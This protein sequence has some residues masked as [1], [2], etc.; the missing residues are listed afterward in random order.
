MAKT[1]KMTIKYWN[2]LSEGS[3]KRALQYCFPIHGAIVEM[4]LDE[5]PTTKE[6]KN[7]W[8]TTVFKKVRIPDDN[9]AYKTVIDNRTYLP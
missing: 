8:W 7:G 4:L 1:K 9:H 5:K 6:I 3:R 2:S